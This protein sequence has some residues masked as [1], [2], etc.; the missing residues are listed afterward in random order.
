[1]QFPQAVCVWIQKHLISVIIL[2]VRSGSISL[3]PPEPLGPLG[4]ARKAALT[5]H[6]HLI[7][8]IHLKE[9]NF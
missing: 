3:W 2:F 5:C 7:W 8:E 9:C 1:M 4:G 6:F